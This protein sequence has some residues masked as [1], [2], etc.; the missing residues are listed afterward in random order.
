M[1][2][3][4]ADEYLGML[5]ALY[6]EESN[7][8]LPRIDQA[9]RIR[10]TADLMKDLT[11]VEKAKVDSNLKIQEDVLRE[12]DQAR[13]YGNFLLRL[14]SPA[15]R[16]N[17]EQIPIGVIPNLD[18]NAATL[19]SPSGDPVIVV[20]SGLM[21]TLF[22][23][24]SWFAGTVDNQSG[25]AEV[26]FI[27][28]TEMIFRWAVF[29][30]THSKEWL[31]PSEFR[32]R[33]YLRIELT[34]GLV[35]N[36]MN[37]VIGHE[38]GHVML[39]HLGDSAVETYSNMAKSDSAPP[40]DK[41]QFAR[42]R[43]HDADS[44]AVTLALDFSKNNHEGWPGAGAAGVELALQFIRLQEELFPKA[45]QKPASHPSTVERLERCR[46]QLIREGGD[47][48]VESVER[49]IASI[50]KCFDAIVAVG[51]PLVPKLAN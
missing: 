11:P 30:N 36:A 48:W 39:G 28:A 12:T 38:F 51:K 20:C 23:V 17:I 6:G 34:A 10:L 31:P 47:A 32:T 16:I 33:N 35:Q 43:E 1:N 42:H 49:E 9:Q 24:A 37:F 13:F 44:V 21:A 8:P 2:Q 25:K 46:S 14:L 15:H 18:F 19:R 29:H 45:T 50:K 40:L 22:E 41:Y 26:G 4:S 7:L 27:E 3:L 5:Q